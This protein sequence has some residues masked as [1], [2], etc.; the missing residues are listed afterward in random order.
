[1]ISMTKNRRQQMIAGWLRRDRVASQEQVVE[2]LAAAGFTV[3]QA[4]VSRDLDELGATKK[5]RG[6][7][8][9]YVLPDVESA[10][11]AA[12]RLT[13]VLSD[14]VT[15]IVEAQGAVVIRCPPGSAPI[16]STAIDRIG[17][18]GV[19][20]TIAGDDTVLLALAPGADPGSM[21]AL[22]RARSGGDHDG[23]DAPGREAS[24]DDDASDEEER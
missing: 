8:L 20:G 16:I 21:A 5:R 15:D 3:T 22:L 12:Q 9:Y 2:R 11:V 13:R 24:G 7:N 23:P 14:W 10:E 4:T 1:M 18:D 6:G 19:A 17:L